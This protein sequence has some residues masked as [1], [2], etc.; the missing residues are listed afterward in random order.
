MVFLRARITLEAWFEGEEDRGIELEGK[1]LIDNTID[2]AIESHDHRDNASRTSK[3]NVNVQRSATQLSL[4]CPMLSIFRIMLVL[5]LL[6]EIIKC[7]SCSRQFESTAGLATHKRACK[8]KIT[9]TATRLLQTCRANLERRADAKR[10]KVTKPRVTI[11]LQQSIPHETP[12]RDA[13]RL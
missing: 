13:R 1:H 10:H 9:A 8:A 6:M 11:L 4:S 12:S 3:F 2:N 7:P 5:L